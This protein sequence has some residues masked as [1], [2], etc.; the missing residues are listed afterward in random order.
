MRRRPNSS[1]E[2]PSLVPMADMLTNTVGIMLFIL[3]FASLS[4]GGAV[5][6]KKLPRER[7]TRAQ[8]VWMLC[9]RGRM[10]TFDADKLD[11]RLRAG[12]SEPT[13]NTVERWAHDYSSRKFETEDLSVS[14]HATTSFSGGFFGQS[15]RLC[16]S[17]E[18]RRKEGRGDDTAAI[19]SE[20]SAFSKMFAER[21][22]DK[23]FFFFLV[24]PESITIYRAARD[25]AVKAGFNVG[26][27]TLDA[28]EPGR[29]NVMGNCGSAANRQ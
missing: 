14:G 26:W 16:A 8:A 20:H 22:K 12:L 27:S 9:S 10:V 29:I 25:A 5:I 7:P 15:V 11:T 1:F 3:I 2:Q 19:K 23:E 28:G 24:D 18:V 4:A 17:V 21:N 13:F 6:Y